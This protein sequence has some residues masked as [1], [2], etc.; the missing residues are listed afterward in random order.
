MGGGGKSDLYHAVFGDFCR[1]WTEHTKELPVDPRL[2][3]QPRTP[4]PR[5]CRNEHFLGI[6]GGGDVAL[7]ERV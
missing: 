3:F 4:V 6:G 7:L 1:L 2:E 5:K